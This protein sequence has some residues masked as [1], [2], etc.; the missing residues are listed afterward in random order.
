MS[1]RKKKLRTLSK[2][3]RVPLKA[4]SRVRNFCFTL[5]NPTPDDR[6]RITDWQDPENRLEGQI[7]NVRFGIGQLEIAPESKTPHLQG[8]IELKNPRR[9]DQIKELVGGPSGK[10]RPHI[11]KR[12]GTAEQAKTYC[13]KPDS[14]ATEPE[15]FY[16]FEFGQMSDNRGNRAKKQKYDNI[17]EDIDDGDDLEQLEEN[18][19]GTFM[20]QKDKIIDHWIEKKGL[21][22]LLPSKDN[23]WIFYG[24]TGTGKTTS[25]KRQFP[26]HYRGCWPTGGRWWWPKYRGQ[27]VII[28]DEFRENLSYQ[29][30]LSVTDIHGMDIE[31]KGGNSQNI[32]KKIIITTSR[33]P[34]E[35]YSGV[36]DKTELQRRIR[37]NCTIFEFTGPCNWDH[38]SGKIEDQCP[39]RIVYPGNEFTF[40]PFISLDFST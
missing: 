8:Y 13:Q 29:Q 4:T 7:S 5:N 34:T 37:E 38:P 1:K 18:Y 15:G 26:E 40:D 2:R 10:G 27:E 20:M 39:R 22:D 24:K 32:S 6:E 11:E 19:P 14:R 25:A 9:L 35:W 17:A 31:Y 33:E 23:V 3:P 12:R 28:L 21:R 30:M 16:R 36:E